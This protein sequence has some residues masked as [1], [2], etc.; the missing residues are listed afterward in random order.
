M[1]TVKRVIGTLCFLVILAAL[2]HGLTFVTRNKNEAELVHPYYD[3]KKD[4][5][6][7]IF[8]GSSH[9]MCGIYPMELY[10]AYGIASYDYTSSALVLPQA[11]Y[12]VMEALR[13]QN[14]K[15]LVLDIS[16]VAYGD[17]KVGSPEYVHV[18]LD[19]MKW[20]LNKIQA[21]NDLIEE[22]SDRMEYYFPLMKFHTRWK[23]LQPEDFRP[24]VGYTKGAHVSDD[25][26]PGGAAYPI[27][28]KDSTAPI[29]QYAETYLRKILDCCRERDIPVLLV[30][31]P[32]IVDDA[33]QEK[34]NAVYAIAEEYG[35]PYL[36]LLHHLD[37]LGF[38]FTVDLKDTSHCNRT[39]AEKVTAYL[40]GYL[41]EHYELPDRRDDPAYQ[42]AWDAAYER[43]IEA[44]PK[45]NG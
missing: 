45:P 40:G 4:S 33:A 42:P 10:R 14:P 44:F 19:N 9:V 28:P 26:L 5:L 15:V 12:Q 1:K 35:L 22:P 32:A 11:Y 3:E 43:Y 39:G 2:V 17:V 23:E 27:K 36:N 7:V 31:L 41:K 8:V 34:Y 24:I 21:I 30:N 13:T 16:G 20:S 29:S 38:D 6:D 37:E 25:I 18:Q